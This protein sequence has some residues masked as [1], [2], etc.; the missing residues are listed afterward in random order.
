[1]PHC[2]KPTKGHGGP[3]PPTGSIYDA[4]GALVLEPAARVVAAVARLLQQCQG[5]GSA[6]AVMRAWA[7]QGLP[8]PRRQWLPGAR[9]ALA[10]GRL[11]L[12]RVFAI[13]PHPLSTGTAVDGRRRSQPVVAA[14][15]G[16]RMRTLQKPQHEW[17]VV[18]PDA[19]PASIR[20]EPYVAHS[21]QL[22]RT[23]TTLPRVS[24][25]P[26]EGAALRQGVV[27]CGRCG[28]RLAVR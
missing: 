16:T 1:M 8:L 3:P 6:F 28:R 22:T 12:G 11:R 27:L 24:G 4:A 13:V 7:A 14:G 25:R 17:P 18:I 2:P 20:W 23:R 5:L 21:A 15:Q 26:R 9:G 19:H 10:W